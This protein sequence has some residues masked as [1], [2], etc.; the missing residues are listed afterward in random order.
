MSPQGLTDL[1]S[2]DELTGV[3]EQQTEQLGGLALQFTGGVP[4]PQRASRGIEPVRPESD[5]RHRHGLIIGGG[6][7]RF[8]RHV[9]LRESASSTS[10]VGVMCLGRSTGGRADEV[11][12]PIDAAGADVPSDLG[13]RTQRP[14]AVHGIR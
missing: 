1:L 12:G 14:R 5:R 6:A 10:G 13:I 4:A 3:F 8:V 11:I 9:P 2:R 7:G